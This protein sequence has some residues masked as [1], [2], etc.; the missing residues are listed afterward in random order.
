MPASFARRPFESSASTI[1]N[2]NG[3]GVEILA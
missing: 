3:D 1:S 2:G